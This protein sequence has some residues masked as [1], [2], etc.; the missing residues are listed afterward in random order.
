[1]IKA[2]SWIFYPIQANHVLARLGG[3]RVRALTL[4]FPVGVKGKSLV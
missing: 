3:A 4:R 1:M 2:K